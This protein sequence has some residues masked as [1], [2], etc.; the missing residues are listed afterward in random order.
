MYPEMNE[1]DTMVLK[2]M[3]EWA[4]LYG[5]DYINAEGLTRLAVMDAADILNMAKEFARTLDYAGLAYNISYLD[6]AV[7][8]SVPDFIWEEVCLKNSEVA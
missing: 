1:K 3:Y 8:D 2:S 6:T 7:R 4:F 5:N